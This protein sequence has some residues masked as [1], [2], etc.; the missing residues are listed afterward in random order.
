MHASFIMTR[1]LVTVGLDDTLADV[2]EIFDTHRF[3]HL[4]VVENGKVAGVV[5]DR[6][7]LKHLS[8]FVGKLSERRQDAFTL[9]KKVHQIMSRHV[10]TCAPETDAASV[11]RLMLEHSVSCLPV[12][13]AQGNIQGIVTWRDLLRAVAICG[14]D[15]QCRLPNSAA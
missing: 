14:I 5:S 9:E 7:L 6:D 13:D 11:T 10:V 1:D 8:P 4:I 3:H 12:V 2:R 15:P